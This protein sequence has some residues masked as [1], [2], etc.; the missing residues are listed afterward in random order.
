MA[1]MNLGI[2]Y[3]ENL[4]FFDEAIEQFNAI[5]S[6]KQMNWWIPKIYNNIRSNRSNKG[7]AY[8]NKGVAYK[9][10]AMYL[11]L[12]KKYMINQYLGDAIEAYNKAAKVLKKSYQQQITYKKTLFYNNKQYDRYDNPPSS[13]HQCFIGMGRHLCRSSHIYKRNERACGHY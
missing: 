13:I 6:I 8:F 10:K 7:I 9:Q 1:R 12:E 5:Q 2:V 11:P 4:G 3:S